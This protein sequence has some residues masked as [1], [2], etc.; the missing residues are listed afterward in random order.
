MSQ[1]RDS[2]DPAADEHA[3]DT[4][5]DSRAQL[6]A[7]LDLL[8]EENRR[9]REES[10]RARKTAYRRTAQGLAAIG[11]VAVVSAILFPTI[12]STL[13]VLGSI[14]LFGGVVTYYLTP[15]RFVA[16]QTGDRIV[17]ALDRS[18]QDL[19]AQL[20][21][22]ADRLLVP[23][24]GPNPARLFVP[25]EPIT[26]LHEQALPPREAMQ[27]S[28]VTD[29]SGARGVSVVPAGADLYRTFEQ[30]T[31]RVEEETL[32]T[33][34]ETLSEALIEQFEL[35]TTI[36]TDLEIADGEATVR[37]SGAAYG[38]P[39]RFD[40]PLASFLGVGIACYLDRPVAVTTEPSD[41]DLLVQYRWA[42]DETDA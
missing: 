5:A 30:E 14:G 13:L 10:R 34:V 2:S 7:E 12:R 31:D 21:L 20:E 23:S 35:A 3:E 40:D 24:A 25:I 37:L 17:A 38:G 6:E 41:E 28:F 42:T 9:L 15:E 18:W 27:S 32:P 19:V 29:E 39:N 26:S 33:H 11:T 8:A 36:E 4:D 16:A 1:Q 22:A